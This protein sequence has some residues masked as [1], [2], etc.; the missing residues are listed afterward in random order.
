MQKK[1]LFLVT[2]DDGIN[3]PGLNALMKAA[4]SFGEVVV[5][6]PSGEMSGASHSITLN[7]S[8][9]ID[10]RDQS[11]YAIDGTPVDCVLCAL[12]KLLTRT[13]D[14][15]LSGIN[16]GA[17]LGS[18]TLFS[19]TVGAAVVGSMHGIT[20]FAVSVA[21]FNPKTDYG[22]ARKVVE[23]LLKNRHLFKPIEGLVLNVNI[24]NL[25]LD[26]I[27]GVCVTNL[28]QRYY[29]VNFIKECPDQERYL[30]GKAPAG[31]DGIAGNDSHEVERGFVTL[32]ALKPS[33]FCQGA[34]T[35]LN[36]SINGD[37]WKSLQEEQKSHHE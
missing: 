30:Y 16:S 3:A 20:S 15:I 32:S 6:A 8:L 24:P 25:P 28:S 26:R 34:N 9:R 10:K 5:V 35:M 13:P 14:Y 1:P 33:L 4:G 11:L 12:R 27:S 2:N 23:M 19:G 21:D 37:L 22:A 29:D 17:N 7:R 36:Q 31:H 18:D